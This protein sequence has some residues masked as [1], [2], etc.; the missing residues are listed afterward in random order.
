M[1]RKEYL[2]LIKW[3]DE[4]GIEVLWKFMNNWRGRLEKIEDAFYVFSRAFYDEKLLNEKLSNNK[5]VAILFNRIDSK[6]QDFV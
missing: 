6:Y 1:Q 4:E 5:S 2:E 3:F